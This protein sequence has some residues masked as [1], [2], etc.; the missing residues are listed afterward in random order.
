MFGYL[1]L[2]FTVLPALELAILI[3]VGAYIGVGNTLSMI[4]LTGIAG[5]SLARYQGFTVMRNI[6]NSLNKGEMPT[7]EMLDGLMIFCGG[8]VLLTPGFITDLLGF[9][10]LIPLTRS[11]IKLWVKKN[12]QNMTAN[13]QVVNLHIPRRK[14]GQDYEDADYRE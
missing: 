13:G 9:F 14:S 4:I 2:L 7:N 5:A 3:R 8:V 11:L 12:I 6:Q 1:I 10:L